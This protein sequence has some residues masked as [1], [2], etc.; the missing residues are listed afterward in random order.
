MLK[1]KA[2][3]HHIKDWWADVLRGMAIYEELVAEIEARSGREFHAP[4]SSTAVVGPDVRQPR[5]FSEF[6]APPEQQSPAADAT[7]AA[8]TTATP[9]TD[10][11]PPAESTAPTAPTAPTNRL[12]IREDQLA[13]L[14]ELKPVF[15]AIR[16]VVVSDK[17]AVADAWK[18]L[19]SHWKVESARS[20]TAG[21]AD[22]L[23]AHIME[24]RDKCDPTVRG[25]FRLG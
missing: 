11:A 9:T 12:P 25:L 22:D 15:L 2:I 16:N 14:A 18:G 3:G 1:W 13:K 7:P 4:P 23:I 8:D 17:Q 10:A 19:L 21:Q 20:L 6:T 5:D 24:A